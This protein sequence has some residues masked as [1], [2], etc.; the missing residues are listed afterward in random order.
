MPVTWSFIKRKSNKKCLPGPGF[1]PGCPPIQSAGIG[2]KW[3]RMKLQFVDNNHYFW[4]FKQNY[5]NCYF[6]EQ[7]ELLLIAH[8]LYEI[9]RIHSF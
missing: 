9:H 6:Y 4:Y 2:T 8:L 5:Y 7:Y 1:E 3:L